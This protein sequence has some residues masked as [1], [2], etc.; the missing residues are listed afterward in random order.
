MREVRPEHVAVQGDGHRV[1]PLRDERLG[2][3]ERDD[4]DVIPQDPG[5]RPPHLGV[6]VDQPGGGNAVA[7]GSAPG[8]LPRSGQSSLVGR[9][10]LGED[11]PGPTPP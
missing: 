9:G 8:A 4:H 10:G 2:V 3:V 7:C 11:S 1:G 5:G 6:A